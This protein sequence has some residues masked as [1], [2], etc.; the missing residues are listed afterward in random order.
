[1]A[2]TA[3]PKLALKRGALITAANWHVVRRAVRRRHRLH[4][5]AGR[6]GRRRRRA[7]RAHLGPRSARR[8]SGKACAAPCRRWRRRCWRIRS[9]S[10][11]SS[12]R[13]SLVLLG[14]SL[15]MAFVK[16]GT[17]AVLAAA[18]REAGPDRTAAAAAG[19]RARRQRASR[20]NA[21]P[22]GAQRLFGRFARL[23]CGAVRRLRRRARPGGRGAS[24]RVGSPDAAWDAA[25]I[26][27]ITA[28]VGHR[29]D[30]R[31][32]AVPA[33]ADRRSPSTTATC[34]TALAR[35]GAAARAA[36]ARDRLRLRRGA[37]RSWRSAP[38]RRCW[39][40]RRSASSRS[41]RSWASRR[42]RCKWRLARARL[43]VPVPRPDGA[44]RLPA[45][46]PPVAAGRG[47]GGDAA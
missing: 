39:P 29:R 43:R 31:E 9:R 2:L 41:C 3:S 5:A 13:W 1:M 12:S 45:A 6:A 26:A 21:P 46:L 16:G 34:A 14:G 4:G 32:P 22:T 42:C 47:D 23:G 36:A 28:G 24:R 40:R 25:R 7:G 27:G 15:F 33:H 44:G 30:A 38:R 18:E 10:A 20:S 8:C 35:D 37:R 17:M 19:G 11:R